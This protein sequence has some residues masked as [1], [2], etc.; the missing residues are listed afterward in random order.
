MEEQRS[1]ELCSCINCIRQHVGIIWREPKGG[2]KEM[3][4]D[5]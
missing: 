3:N 1:T 2:E 4:L 5:P